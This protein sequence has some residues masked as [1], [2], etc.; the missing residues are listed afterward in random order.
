MGGLMSTNRQTNQTEKR[1][2]ILGVHSLDSFHM[3]VPDLKEADHF[4]TAFGLVVE[5]ESD[6]LGV[7]TAGSR[8]R[9]IQ[10]SESKKK[11]LI[12]LSFSVFD[13]DFDLL[14]EQVEKEVEILSED[15]SNDGRK[16]FSFKD[17]N[18]ITI[19]I[20][21][22]TKVTLESKAKFG[23][24]DHS[25]REN[26]SGSWSRSIKPKITPLRLS[27]ILI[28]TPSVPETIAFY[29]KT[30]G[31]KLSDRTEDLIAFMHGQHG[32]DHHLIAFAMSD[33]TPA[34]LHH[35]SWDV[36]SINAIGLGTEQMIEAGYPRHWGLGRHVVG[37]N[38]FSYVQDPWGSW[39]EYS[40]DIDYISH[41]HNWTAKNHPAEDGIYVWG[42]E[43]PEDFI[44]NYEAHQDIW[45]LRKTSNQK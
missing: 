39:C 37:S 8:H 6:G 45:Q 9:W 25:T 28:F 26:E 4:Y 29:A 7:Y 3:C 12:S 43:L 15:K 16:K 5:H 41:D 33:G 36:G 44:F 11:K 10:I 35:C 38:Y 20:V 21:V 2:N 22:G 18:A 27:H 14:K 40:A 30:L 23:N 34:A 19:E 13:Q 17:N 24:L 32:S 1:K 42:P 31:L